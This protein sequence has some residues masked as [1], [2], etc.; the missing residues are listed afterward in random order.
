MDDKFLEDPRV[1]AVL[2]ELGWGDRFESDLAAMT[3]GVGNGNIMTFNE[4]REGLLER[5][6]VYRLKGGRGSPYLSLTD[7]GLSVI[8]NM[9][10]DQD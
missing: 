2:I 6:L 5:A 1:R 3:V 8:S 7:R 10:R 4:V 9:Q